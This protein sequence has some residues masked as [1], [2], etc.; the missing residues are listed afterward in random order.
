MIGEIIQ[1][2]F[3]R[4][5]ERGEGYN[6]VNTLVYGIGFICFSY[7]LFLLL[8]RLKVKP[9]E[10]LLIGGF[11]FLLLGPAIRVLVDAKVYPK[12]FFLVTPGIFFLVLLPTLVCLGIAKFIEAKKGIDYWKV[13]L[14]IS[15]FFP[16]PFLAQLRLANPVG[17]SFFLLYFSLTCLPFAFL[18]RYSTL[19]K[20]N[21]SFLALSS[22]LLDASAT[23]V[24]LDFFG[25]EEQ[26]F[27]PTLLIS[28]SG[29]ALVMYPLKLVIIFPIL[30]AL[31]RYCELETR[32]YIKI[33][34][35][36]L[37]L[38]PALRDCLR[39]AMLV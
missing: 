9:D 4:P 37:G 23:Y 34:I 8:K 18:R 31:E 39:L 6:P 32:N 36:I 10:R 30:L 12:N 25:Y 26:H 29:T 7:L 28:L 35:I 21:L 11:P 14:P 1:R 5:I 38:A 33:L 27:L 15:A 22:H 13:M 19:L 20:N 17:F 24:S 3:I 2:F 16:I